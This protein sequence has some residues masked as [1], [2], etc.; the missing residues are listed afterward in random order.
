[1]LGNI[2]SSTMFRYH[3][4]GIKLPTGCNVTVEKETITG[5]AKEEFALLC[6]AL[7]DL[8]NR[9]LEMVMISKSKKIPYKVR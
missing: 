7:S 3:E 9:V 4:F 8:D 5:D 1:M 6:K 2:Y